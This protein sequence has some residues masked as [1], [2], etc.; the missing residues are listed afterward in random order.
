[1]LRKPTQR[2][3]GHEDVTFAEGSDQSPLGDIHRLPTQLPLEA[4]HHR[5]YARREVNSV[6][7]QLI[8]DR[9]I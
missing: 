6:V 4:V 7:I 1:M 8:H 2:P 3:L 9:S 5:L